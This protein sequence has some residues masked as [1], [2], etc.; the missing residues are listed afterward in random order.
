MTHEER[1]CKIAAI[2]LELSETKPAERNAFYLAL[3]ER[4]LNAVED[5]PKDEDDDKYKACYICHGSGHRPPAV[6]QLSG[7][8]VLC[9]VCG[10][11]GRLR[12]TE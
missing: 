5:K 2:L 9:F 10:G 11:A 6:P 1:I 4:L 3:A 12:K 8:D 7:G